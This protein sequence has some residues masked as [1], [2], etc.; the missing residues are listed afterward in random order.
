MI[1]L[2]EQPPLTIALALA[3]GLGLLLL[4][5]VAL[6]SLVSA[7]AP[8]EI[9]APPRRG[10][11][12]SALAQRPFE[13]YA[14]VAE[15]PLFNPGRKKD[16]DIAAAVVSNL[17]AL[18]DYRLVGIVLSPD[19]KL[20]LVTRKSSNQVVTLRPGDNLD[21]RHVDD[22]EDAGVLLSGA[23]SKEVLSIPRADGGAWQ[24]AAPAVVGPSPIQH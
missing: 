7:D 23:G 1:R 22:V 16:P 4:T 17:P 9:A 5:S 2:T 12:A 11:S 14:A 15:R 6:P 19:A 20:A 18:S 13:T 3:A 24:S 10:I 21:G 8:G